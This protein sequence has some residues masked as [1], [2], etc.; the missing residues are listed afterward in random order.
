[1]HTACIVP[2]CPRYVVKRSRCQVHQRTDEQLGYGAEWRRIRREVRGAVCEA[3][4]SARDLTVD[5][6]V[7][8]S[9]GGTHDYR[10]LRTLCR[11]CHGR[12][13][14]QSNRRARDG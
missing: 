3:C 13:G 7:P 9:L 1:M 5:H 14:A 11:S 6:I 4:G 12:I 2:G 8:M 10:N